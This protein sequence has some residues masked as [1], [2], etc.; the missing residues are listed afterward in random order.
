L[1]L[2][3]LPIPHEEPQDFVPIETLKLEGFRWFRGPYLA[4]TAM[5]NCGNMLVFSAGHPVSTSE[6]FAVEGVQVSDELLT[7]YA[8]LIPGETE[9]TGNNI[10]SPGFLRIYRLDNPQ[11]VIGQGRNQVYV[12]NSREIRFTG[13]SA[14]FCSN[15]SLFQHTP[16]ETTIPFTAS[17]IFGRLLRGDER[18]NYSDSTKIADLPNFITLG[19]KS[20]LSFH[21][22]HGNTGP[23]YS[24]YSVEVQENTLIITKVY[25]SPMHVLPAENWQDLQLHF[26]AADFV[27]I[28]EVELVTIF[29]LVPFSHRRGG[30]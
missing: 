3:T 2:G 7:L 11:A 23:W 13:G 24:I 21:Y 22:R 8:Y 25:S 5:L 28:T 12:T 15:D 14:I 30:L 4:G 26:N 6:G 10:V 1:T 18:K 27:G 29:Y 9:F 20:V 17:S 16:A 19:N